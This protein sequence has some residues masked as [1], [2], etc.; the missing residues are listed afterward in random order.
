MKIKEIGTLVRLVILVFVLMPLNLLAESNKE[1][2]DTWLESKLETTYVFNPHINPF[3]IGVDVKNG[4]VNLSGAVD[5]SVDKDLAEEIAKSLDGVKSVKNNIIVEMGTSEKVRKERLAK[6]ERSFGEAVSDS[7]ITAQVK[8]K[9]LW[10]RQT[11][12]FDINVTTNSGVVTLGG[13]AGSSAIKELAERLAKNTSGVK[14]VENELKVK[15]ASKLKLGNVDLDKAAKNGKSAAANV[16]EDISDGWISTKVRSSLIFSSDIDSSYI[17][18]TT[19][20]G[21][22]TLNGTALTAHQK[23]RAEKIATDIKGVKRI[24]NELSIA[25]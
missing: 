19:D 2:S 10:N 15:D 4:V 18:V 16:G 20:K 17:D 6:N 12:G 1:H 23:D 22:V 7:T 8:S 9:L 11:D 24:Q 5:E 13:V 21:I 14:K 25:G 3:E